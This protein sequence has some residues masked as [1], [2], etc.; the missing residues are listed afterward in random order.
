MYSFRACTC[1]ITWLYGVGYR[2]V[3][4]SVGNLVL[5][6]ATEVFKQ[7]MRDGQG[8]AE[9]DKAKEEEREKEQSRQEAEAGGREGP[10]PWLDPADIGIEAPMPPLL[11]PVANTTGVDSATSDGGDCG[12]GGVA[13]DG[14]TTTT[15]VARSLHLVATLGAAGLIS[16]D[17]EA[18]LVGV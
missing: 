2:C 3:C 10:C 5:R 7:H 15:A 16:V 17:S 14:S 1:T 6:A 8:Q 11:P 9:C 18:I 4:R 13:E 12:G